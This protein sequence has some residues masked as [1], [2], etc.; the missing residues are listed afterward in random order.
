MKYGLQD[1]LFLGNLDALIE[2]LEDELA[3]RFDDFKDIEIKFLFFSDSLPRDE[4]KMQQ[5]YQTE[6]IDL[7]NE[8]VI[9]TT[10]T[11]AKLEQFYQK[12]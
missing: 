10:H 8:N 9:K 2:N 11:K 3:Y 1:K 7:R 4:E 12:H 5:K 6:L